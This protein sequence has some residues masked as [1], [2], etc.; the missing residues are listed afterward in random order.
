MKSVVLPLFSCIIIL[1]ACSTIERTNK[2]PVAS[3]WSAANPSSVPYD[4]RRRQFAKGNLV[5]NPAFEDGRW[6]KTGSDNLFRLTGW[7]TV[8]RHIQWVDRDSSPDAFEGQQSGRRCINIAR[9]QANETDE[10]EGI[11]SDYIPVIPGN[12]DF[13]Y[14]VRLQDI[15]S[16]KYRLGVRLYDA[17][18]VNVLFFDEDKQP[19]N[20]ARVN[21][22]S[23]GLIDNSDK[24]Y[25]F[26]NFW[27]IERFPWGKVRGRSYNYPFSEGDIP[28]RTCYVRLFLG[29]KGTAQRVA[30]RYL[31]RLLEMEFYRVGT[32]QAFF[33]TAVSRWPKR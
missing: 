23:G 2:I 29:L 32:L 9:A 8:G 3:A 13:T 4:I 22:V 5:T 10:A 17:I 27:R 25:S 18:V 16:N 7:E 26:S 11:I 1:A 12:Y 31:F 6:L 20:P 15:M 19:L 14:R 28:D 30:G 33:L 21:P 24:S